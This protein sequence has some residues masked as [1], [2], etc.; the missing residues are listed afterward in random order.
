MSIFIFIFFVSLLSVLFISN[1]I[2]KLAIFPE[3]LRFTFQRGHFSTQLFLLYLYIPEEA[4]EMLEIKTTR[5]TSVGFHSKRRKNLGR[6]L[7]YFFI[8]AAS[9]LNSIERKKLP[10]LAQMEAP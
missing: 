1:F 8:D 9:R 5:C 10:H 7:K 6:D 4:F 2:R 3:G